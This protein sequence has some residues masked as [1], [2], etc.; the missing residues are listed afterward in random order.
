LLFDREAKGAVQG[1]TIRAKP[2]PFNDVK[3]STHIMQFAG[4]VPSRGEC[5][6][7]PVA[8]NPITPASKIFFIVMPRLLVVLFAIS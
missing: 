7:T 5:A 1:M 2:T 8:H 4:I 3:T 6:I